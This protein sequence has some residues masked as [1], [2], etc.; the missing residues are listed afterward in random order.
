MMRTRSARVL[1][2]AETMKISA[3]SPKTEKTT[4]GYSRRIGASARREVIE[5]GCGEASQ[6][7]ITAKIPISITSLAIDESSEV[8]IGQ[9][10]SAAGLAA[11]VAS[12]S[13]TTLPVTSRRIS[14]TTPA[15]I[16]PIP[17][18]STVSHR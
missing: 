6:A 7:A 16:S 15:A 13:V 17:A 9:V 3:A 2:A 18:P 11:S 12:W 10:A 4:A 5:L 8:A 1:S 14:T